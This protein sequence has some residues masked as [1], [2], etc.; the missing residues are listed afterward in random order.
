MFRGVS[1]AD[2]GD[3]T[4]V[5]GL[6][7]SWRVV[8]TGC[9]A[10]LTA[11]VVTLVARTGDP[12]TADTYLLDAVNAAVVLPDGSSVT[13]AAG[14]LVPLGGTVRTGTCGP[15]ESPRP[16]GAARLRTAD[17]DV[18]LGADSALRVVDGV[19]Q[20]LDKGLVMVD[21]RRGPRL[22]LTTRGG[23]LAVSD[24][25]LVRAEL[26][27]LLMRVGTFTGEAS[28]AAVGRRVT[29]EVPALHQIRAPYVGLPGPATALSLTGDSWEQRLAEPL[30]AADRDLVRLAAALAGPTGRTVLT[31]APAAL[32]TTVTGTGPVVLGELGESALAVAVAQAGRNDA[33]PTARLA[34]VRE[35]RAEGGSWGVVAAIVQARVSA[36]SSVLDVWLADP[37]ETVPPV[38]AVPGPDLG[39]IFGTP[40]PLQPT[41]AP[42]ARPTRTGTSPSPS[43]SA[44]P[45][46]SASPT[47]PADD[48]ITT[49]TGLL[50]PPPSRA[51]GGSSPTPLIDLGIIKIG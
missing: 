36:V 26:G 19:Q 10:V 34:Q 50:S 29:T 47:T 28:L 16:C 48:L 14:M 39:G 18:Y 37:G 7:A 44:T 38:D 12:A 49:L 21:S 1:R 42:T 24:G 45:K 13:A 23:V 20:A 25:A 8:L 9:L 32:R 17:R 33:S 11:A 30:V 27:P 6:L 15:T 46:P 51:P 22:S 41:P 40:Q 31:V 2:D 3:V 35:L 43:A 5:S 4:D